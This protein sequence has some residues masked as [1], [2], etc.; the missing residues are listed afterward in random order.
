MQLRKVCNHPNLFDPRPTV[1]PYIETAL[2]YYI[3]SISTSVL[4]YK[5]LSHVNFD[6]LNLLITKLT[7][8]DLY[9]QTKMIT[10]YCTESNLQ[11]VCSGEALSYVRL[12]DYRDF[13]RMLK[14]TKF[15]NNEQNLNNAKLITNSSLKVISNP[16]ISKSFNNATNSLL[17]N[18][19]IKIQ[20]KNVD[21]LNGMFIMFYLL[22]SIFDFLISFKS[23]SAESSSYSQVNL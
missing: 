3:P 13:V 18:N 2:C 5:P 20:P 17:L 8:Y 22:I 11:S 23:I 19:S 4:D 14:S 6:S 21:S 1:S 10:S 7:N 12:N 9:V 16:F 15:Y